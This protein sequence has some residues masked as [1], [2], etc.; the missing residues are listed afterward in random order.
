MRKLIVFNNVTLDGYFAG[1]GGD[2]SWA[3]G[4]QNDPEWHAF[5]AGNAVGGGVILLGRVTYDLMAGYWPTP[6]ARQNDPVVAE[7]MNA[8]RKIVFSRTMSHADWSN[9]TLI[10]DDIVA[11]VRRLKSE[12]GE[13]MAILGSGSI[14]MQLAQARL[15]DEFQIVVRPVVLGQGHSLFAGLAAPL[16]LKLMSSRTFSNGNVFLR[17]EPQA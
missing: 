16:S 12:P 14:T 1:P 2:L 5:V 10:K 6:L 3:H 11:A 13:G 4:N 7:R 9:T 15:I 8:G 17:Y